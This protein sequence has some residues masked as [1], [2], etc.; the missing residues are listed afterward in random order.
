[1]QKSKPEIQIEQVIHKGE[2][3]IKLIFFYDSNLITEVRKIPGCRWSASMKCWHAPDVD[4]SREK[5]NKL[6]VTYLSDDYHS[7]KTPE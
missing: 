2:Q 3:R 1:M 6:E 5:L 4:G 7:T